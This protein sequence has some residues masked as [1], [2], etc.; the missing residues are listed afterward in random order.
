MRNT[1]LI[2]IIIGLLLTLPN[3]GFSQENA[4]IC[5]SI[6]QVKANAGK[7]ILIFGELARHHQLPHHPY[8][9]LLEGNEWIF[10]GND[11]F[12]GGKPINTTFILV[13]GIVKLN[14]T[15]FQLASFSNEPLPETAFLNASKQPLVKD[16]EKLIRV[17]PFVTKVAQIQAIPACHSQ[18]D[19]ETNLNQWVVVYGLISV[20]D[21]QK[22]VFQ[23][24]HKNPWLL[25][26][27]P[28]TNALK[29]GKKQ[30][31][32]AIV[33]FTQAN[34]PPSATLLQR[35][36][37]VCKTIE[38]F[39]QHQGQL[40]A[41]SGKVK[42]KG[43]LKVNRK[44][45]LYIYQLPNSLTSDQLEGKKVQFITRVYHYGLPHFFEL[46]LFFNYLAFGQ[47]GYIK[48]G[49]WLDQGN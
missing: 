23:A 8:I 48:D 43:K 29:Q 1:L 22:V 16:P 37:P 19:I 2:L 15:D 38:Q 10:L 30:P 6:E 11:A 3:K 32:M 17:H 47:I 26:N 40:V 45:L 25:F 46:P 7:Q 4:P 18:K 27:M 35:L 49:L 41:F 42:K 31:G 5:T 39:R 14:N 44:T 13:K 33:K 20:R 12:F 28:S 21:E 24:N 34:Q 36:F 9:L